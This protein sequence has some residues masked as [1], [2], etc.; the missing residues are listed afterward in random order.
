[1]K[2]IE[3]KLLLLAAR[4]TVPARSSFRAASHPRVEVAL[5]KSAVASR[6]VPSRI[7]KAAA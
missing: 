3:P 5:Q 6:L 4:C 7:L 2:T 1:M